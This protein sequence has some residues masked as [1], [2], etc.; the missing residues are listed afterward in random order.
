MVPV[1]N[2]PVPSLAILVVPFNVRA[3]AVIAILPVVAVNPAPTVSAPA[4][5]IDQLVPET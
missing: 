1:M 5:V 3:P 4:A 2:V